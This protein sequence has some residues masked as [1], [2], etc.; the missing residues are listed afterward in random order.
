MARIRTIKPEFWTDEKIVQLPFSAR[1][2]FI[3]LWNFADDDGRI[4]DE[5]DRLRMQIM[6]GDPVDMELA[7]DVLVAAELIER[8]Y[9]D[10]G[11]V[12]LVIPGFGRHQ[13]ISHKSKSKLPLDAYRK[14]V[15]PVAARRQV[16][17]KYGCTPG[18]ENH[19]AECY[20][21][22]APGSIF[23]PKRSDGKPSYWVAFS[24]LE[25]DHF[26]P[27]HSGGVTDGKNLVLSCRSCNRSRGHGNPH[28]FFPGNSGGLRNPPS[29]RE[30][31]GKEGNRKDPKPAA[32]EPHP[33]RQQ[34]ETSAAQ[35]ASKV[36]PA[37]GPSLA[38]G[39]NTRAN[40][41]RVEARVRSALDGGPQDLRIG[42]IAKLEA[43]GLD[44]EAEIVPALLDIAASSRIP[45]RTWT[46]YADRVAERVAAQRQSRVAQGLAAV[47]A[48]PTP[49]ED[50]VDL[51]VSGQWPEPTLRKWIERFRQDA[52][53][54]SE[55]VFGPPPGQPGC[56][57]PSRLLLEAA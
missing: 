5:P 6:P 32:A 2:V 17:Q 26:T 19:P 54:W 24:G 40:F 4:R 22:G 43:D 9:G 13:L 7:L 47:P 1:L 56:R 16:A 42:P 38:E 31:N 55:A 37:A 53:S 3:G 39:W 23:W 49:A 10:D 14:A 30:G 45:I 8:W 25:L 57:I 20:F 50:L 41:D 36:E 28:D 35:P 33:T 29:G 34:V 21:C 48:A 51:G 46:V 52:G 44:L 11:S 15:I 27:E 12:V 18:N